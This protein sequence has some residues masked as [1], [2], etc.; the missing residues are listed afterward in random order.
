MLIPS[1]QKNTT[2]NAQILSQWKCKNSK[3]NPKNVTIALLEASDLDYINEFSKQLIKKYGY[4]DNTRLDIL[5]STINTA[6]IIL[7]NLDNIYKK[8]KIFM[9]I[10]DSKPCGFLIANIEKTS[11]ETNTP[12]YSARHNSAKK[13]TEIDW[14]LTW[15][16]NRNEKIQGIGKAIVGEY[17]HTLKKD[18]FR[19]VYVRS[20]IPEKSEAEFFYESLGFQKLS[21][22]RKKIFTKTTSLCVADKFSN[23]NDDVIP[24]IVTSG[25]H[26][27]IAKEL[28]KKMF[29]REF[30]K[31]TIDI[32]SIVEKI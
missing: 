8:A 11:Q 23:L 29:R 2:F 7:E 10:Q 26:K 14:L 1:I 13:E 25:K 20:E 18:G 17:F 32:R 31:N 30:V 27:A 3:G 12:I 16:P 28:A 5:K 19:D 21:I 24:M 22:K 6:K 15:N 4:L 9:A